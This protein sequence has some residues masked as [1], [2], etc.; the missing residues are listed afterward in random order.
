M[1]GLMRKDLLVL[2]KQL[3]TYLIFLVI[4]GA[5]SVAGLFPLAAVAAMIQI[6]MV[7]LPISAF[8]FDEIARWDRYAAALPGAYSSRPE[9]VLPLVLTSFSTGVRPSPGVST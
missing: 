4:Y 7:M 1:T 5:L 9:A 2:R 6:L 8:S 3:R